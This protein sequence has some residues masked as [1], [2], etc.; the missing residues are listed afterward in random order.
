M[1]VSVEVMST[2]EA[3]RSFIADDKIKEEYTEESKLFR[4][5][6]LFD[7][8]SIQAFLDNDAC[9]IRRLTE[10]E[11]ELLGIDWADGWYVDDFR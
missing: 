7:D 11:C 2:W 1:K 3:I 6:D 4:E 10:D 5:M 8:E 9:D